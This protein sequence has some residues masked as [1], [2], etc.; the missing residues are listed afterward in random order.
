MSLK[1]QCEWNAEGHYY[2]L[3]K[4]VKIPVRLF[5]SPKL[6]QESEE[7][8]Y[9][10]V[11]AATE[12]PGVLDV[13]ITPDVHT[14]YVVPVGCVMATSGTLCQAPVGYDIGCFTADTLIP[15]ADGNVC[16]IGELA[17]A[18]RELNV[19]AITETHRITIA[20][21]TAKLTRRQ[22]PL[23]RVTLDNERTI[24]CTPDHEFML[25]DGSYRE[26]RELAP[27]TSLMPFYHGVDHEGYRY[28]QQPY[29]GRDQRVHWMVARTG[30]LGDIPG[31]PAS[32]PSFIIET[33]SQETIG[34]KIW[35]LWGTATICH[36]TILS[37]NG[38][39]IF[40]AR[41]SKPSV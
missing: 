38:I 36:C 1:W 15:L 22:A 30:L 33:S 7:D 19:F 41:N 18:G 13:V 39:R 37:V 6:Y 5:L 14:G 32:V 23:V 27:G 9:R 26:A 3:N 16:P 31:F 24:T 2:E 25:R 40:T 34:Q 35:S 11:V 29:S 17:S 4:G 21:A 20:K 8:L 12:F 10:Q 28:V